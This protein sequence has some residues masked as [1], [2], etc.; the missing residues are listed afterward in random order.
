MFVMACEMTPEPTDR[1]RLRVGLM[2]AGLRMWD[3]RSLPDATSAV[4]DD[5]VTYCLTELLPYL[6]LSDRWLLEAQNCPDG[7][8]L[9]E[10]MRAENRTMAA[11]VDEL[12]TTSTLSVS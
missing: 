9:A 5:L 2:S 8:L 11:A 3:A 7:R 10:A 1:D 6:E 12:S 4:L